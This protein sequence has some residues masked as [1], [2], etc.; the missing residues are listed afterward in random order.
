MD[1]LANG[2]GGFAVLGLIGAAAAVIAAGTVMVRAFGVPVP[3][4]ATAA[5]VGCAVAAWV[6]RAVLVGWMWLFALLA[7]LAVV[8]CL[9]ALVLSY[10]GVAERWL[11]L[12]LNRD[13]RVGR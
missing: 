9:A 1:V 8:F 7:V 4:R 2:H 10:R 12:D 6:V 5:A 13:G 3:W 11:R